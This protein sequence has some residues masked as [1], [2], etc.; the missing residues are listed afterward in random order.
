MFMSDEGGM[1]QAAS[2]T[3]QVIEKHQLESLRTREVSRLCAW[4]R[5]QKTV[6]ADY[7][8]EMADCIRVTGSA[9]FDICS[10]QFS[11]ITHSAV[12]EIGQRFGSY[13]LVCTRFGSVAHANGI[14]DLFRQKLNLRN[15]PKNLDAM[16]TADIWFTKWGQD[17]HDFANFV[18]LIKE[19]ATAYPSRNF[20]LRPHPSEGLVFYQ[21]AFSPFKNV[22]VVREG[23][24]INWI[25]GADLVV[26]CNCTT[27]IEAMLAGRPVLN[28][29]PAQRDRSKLDVVVAREAGVSTNSIPQALQ[30]AD[31]LLRGERRVLHWSSNAVSILNNLQK[32]AVPIL[33]DETLSVLRERGIDRS[34]IVLPPR[35]R[36][37]GIRASLGRIFRAQSTRDEGYVASKRGQIDRTYVDRFLDGCRMNGVGAGRIRE[38]SPHYVVIDP[39]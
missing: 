8:P 38:F 2:W 24:V 16:R 27:G 18:A 17:V 21:T 26:H 9:R 5:K 15:G 25:R 4:G 7:A 13:I 22:R 20:I 19:L 37:L 1:F 34:R 30:A 14:H 10:P 35:H 12:E 32:D 31:A 33:V 28:F 6:M 36:R 3:E 23:S 11:W 29:L 39:T